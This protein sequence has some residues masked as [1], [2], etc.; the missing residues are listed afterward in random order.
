[1]NLPRISLLFFLLLS[2]MA[3]SEDKEEDATPETEETTNNGGTVNNNVSKADLLGTWA[4]FEIKGSDEIF[5]G[6]DQWVPRY[7]TDE[8][9]CLIEDLELYIDY[10]EL[11]FTANDSLRT[12]FSQKEKER[13]P[14]VTNASNCSISYDSWVETAES[15]DRLEAFELID[16]RTFVLTKVDTIGGNPI[17]YQ[18]SMRYVMKGNI[19]ELDNGQTRLQ[20]Q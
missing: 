4:V 11:T 3:C 1:M 7:Y 19:L 8:N 14:T 9:N 12:N 18:D 2:L 6:L 17:S 16:S 5:Y 15:D 20:K 10:Y 13:N